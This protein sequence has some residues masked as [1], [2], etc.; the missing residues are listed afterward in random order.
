MERKLRD[1]PV[2]RYSSAWLSPLWQLMLHYTDMFKAP[3]FKMIKFEEYYKSLTEPSVASHFD[4]FESVSDLSESAATAIWWNGL[5]VLKKNSDPVFE[6][7]KER[8]VADKNNGK[9]RQYWSDRKLARE[10]EK[11]NKAAAIQTSI[12]I[13]HTYLFL[14]RRLLTRHSSLALS[15]L[16]TSAPDFSLLNSD[17]HLKG[18]LYDASSHDHHL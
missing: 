7:L 9:S 11:T 14:T 15:S 18:V 3:G 13:N 4:F 1:Q 8:Y 12:S 17:F 6:P 16:L 5:K 2:K 10:E